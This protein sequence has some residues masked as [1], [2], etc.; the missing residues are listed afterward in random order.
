MNKLFFVLLG[1]VVVLAALAY[2]KS[3]ATAA[4]G[5]TDAVRLLVNIFP[6]IAVGFLLAG[7]ITVLLPPDLVAEWAGEGS[8]L[9]GLLVG[10]VAGMFAPGGP[11]IQFPVVAGIWKAGAGLGPVTAY[12]SAWSLLAV[13]RAVM[14][15]G[16]ILSWRFTAAR[17]LVCVTLPP[18]I[19]FLAEQV[20]RRLPDW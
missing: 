16:P 20:Y 1:L 8:G 6:M 15:E 2:L 9:K 11:Y 3:P 7:F 14:Y 13:H 10:T 5:A 4:R 17:L 19:G 12:V 18:L